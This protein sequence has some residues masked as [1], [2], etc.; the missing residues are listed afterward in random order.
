MPIRVAINGFGRIGR[1]VLRTAWN[2]SDI[3]FVH[4]NDLTSDAML[5]HLLKHDTVHGEFAE[6]VE[7]VDGGIRIGDRVVATSAQRDPS[8]L[9]WGDKGVDVVLEC[10]GAFRKRAG[11]MLHIDAGAKKVIVSAPGTDMDGTF[12]VGVNSDTIDPE[13]HRIVSNASCTTNCLAPAAKVLHENFGIRH[14]LITTVHAYTMDQRLLDAPHKDFRRA[15]AA[16]QNVVPTSTGA[17]KAVGLVL[18]ELAGKLNGMAIRVPTPNVSL[19][20]LVVN[21]DA[22]VTAEQVN[23]AFVEA[24]EGPLAGILAAVDAPLV[25]TDLVGNPHSSIVDLPLT[26]VIGDRMLKVLTW[27]DNEWGFSNRMVDLARLLFA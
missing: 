14:G 8:A 25:S 9:P 4:I 21:L 6:D 11:A 23:A 2:D 18:P 1:N 5:S 13:R 10:T 26:A 17:A 27:Y 22:D 7:A 16:A 15:R 3:E 19:V 24:A 12:V 20:D